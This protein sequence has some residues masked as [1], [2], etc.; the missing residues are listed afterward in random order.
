M[1]QENLSRLMYLGRRPTPDDEDGRCHICLKA[2]PLTRE[3]VPPRSAFNDCDSLW[4]RLAIHEKEAENS[5]RLKIRGGFWVETICQDCNN[6]VCSPYAQAYVRFVRHLVES[7]K[8]FDSSGRARFV[9]VP[10]DTLLL[11]KQFATMVLAIES[12]KY[13]DKNPDLRN[14]VLDP[15]SVIQ[16]RFRFLGFL[17]PDRPEVGTITRYHAR[18]DTF[19]KGYAFCG[20]EISSFPFGFVY[21]SEIGPGY[22]P[23]SLTDL[24]HWFTTTTNLE[25]H[26]A[27]ISLQCR[28]TG[29][30]SIQV[31]LGHPRM[32]PQI[33][34]VTRQP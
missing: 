19:A 18:V 34:F 23:R 26:S 2:V 8:L 25:R 10:T 3:H 5:R 22:H 11:A 27:V 15:Q 29:A 16:P 12:V 14:F 33:D 13:A 31:G 24:T 6:R 9:T 4:D 30:D 1:D 21:S 7:P 20:G 32:R 17:V 28:L